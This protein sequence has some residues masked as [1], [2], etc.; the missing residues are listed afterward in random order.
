MCLEFQSFFQVL[1]YEDV[2]KLIGPP[3]YA[4]KVR[5]ENPEMVLPAAAEL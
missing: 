4:N 5:V 1:T 3:L 2:E